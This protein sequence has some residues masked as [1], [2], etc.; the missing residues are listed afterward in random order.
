MQTQK[1]QKKKLEEGSKEGKP[2][3]EQGAV[4]GLEGVSKIKETSTNGDREEGEMEETEEAVVRKGESQKCD[5]DMMDVDH[6][7]LMSDLHD[8][9]QAALEAAQMF[10]RTE[11]LNYGQLLLLD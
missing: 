7:Q 10:E 11:S 9:D 8:E 4:S 1:Q 2:L 3:G 5:S 6:Q